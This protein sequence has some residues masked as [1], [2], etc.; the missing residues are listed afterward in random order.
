LQGHYNG[1]YV[2]GLRAPVV[3]LPSEPRSDNL[4]WD[5]DYTVIVSD[6]YHDEHPVMVKERF[7]VWVSPA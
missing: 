1:Q 6:W 5:E 4:T 7:L 3:I 2:D